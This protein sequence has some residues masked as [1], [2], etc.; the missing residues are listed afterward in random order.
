MIILTAMGE[1]VLLILHL[2]S[3][4]FLNDNLSDS[5]S[6]MLGYIVIAIVGLYILVNW[7]VVAVFM[8]KD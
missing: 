6:N 3:I 2:I 1:V 7:V 8:Y 5:K 4:A